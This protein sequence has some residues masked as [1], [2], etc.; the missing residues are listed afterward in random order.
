MKAEVW[1]GYDCSTPVPVEVTTEEA[2]LGIA[3]ID[4]IECGGGGKF[5]YHPEGG[6]L[7]DCVECKGTG[8]ITISC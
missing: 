3:C 4:C 2:E 1:R 6:P 7:R 8:K 5:L